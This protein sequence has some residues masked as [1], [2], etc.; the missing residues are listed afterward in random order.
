MVRIVVAVLRDPGVRFQ[1]FP[2]SHAISEGGK[3]AR[4]RKGEREGREVRRKG[5]RESS[6]P[7]PAFKWLP[8]F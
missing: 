2:L 8:S 4:E 1:G 5:E 7:T 6:Q 3:L